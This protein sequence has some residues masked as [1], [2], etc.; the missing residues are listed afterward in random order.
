MTATHR[1]LLLDGRHH[2]EPTLTAVHQGLVDGLASAGWTIDDWPLRDADITWCVGCFGCWTKTPGVCVQRGAARE[3][4]ARMARAELM[5]Y[6]TPVTF[7]GYSSQLKKALD[8][9][10]PT[11]LPDL[12]KIGPETH[13]PH[14][15]DRVPDL[16]VVGTVA[17]GAGQGREAQ[18]FRRL[19]ARNVLNL[20]PGR[21]AVAV[22]ENGSDERQVGGA[23]AAL[24]ADLDIRP[25]RPQGP[26]LPALS[27]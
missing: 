27:A 3:V 15:Y 23:V 12:R 25:A 21:W 18:T 5:V 7:G 24:L 17:A 22:L 16:L 8:H 4:A 11:V 20:R 26:A 14:R 10:I 6:L 13:H 1:A 2:D 19:V 9:L